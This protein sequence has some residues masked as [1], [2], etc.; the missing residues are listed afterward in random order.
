MMRRLI[1][2]ALFLVSWILRPA[3]AALLIQ[4]GFDLYGYNG[5]WATTNCVLDSRMFAAGAAYLATS[6]GARGGPCL[7]ISGNANGVQSGYYWGVRLP[8]DKVD[9][10]FGVRV[11]P[12]YCAAASTEMIRVRSAA[13]AT[14]FCLDV[15]NVGRIRVKAAYGGAV[16]A[17]SADG[18][19]TFDVFQFL[20]VQFTCDGTD[21]VQVWVDGVEKIALTS[22]L[23]LRQS[24]AGGFGQLMLGGQASTTSFNTY[25][26]DLYIL[27]SSGDAPFND[28]LGDQKLDGHLPTA[29]GTGHD[30]THTAASV[31]QSINVVGSAYATNYTQSDTVGQRAGVAITPNSFTTIHA[32]TIRAYCRNPGGG[33]AK[34]RPYVKIGGTRYYGDEVTLPAD[35]CDLREYVWYKNPALSPPNDAWTTAALGSAELGWE[36]TELTAP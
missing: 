9:G 34:F 31:Y 14:Q 13:A 20:E 36:T 24:G 29:D 3:P 4:E 33:T 21:T 30:W 22:S 8:A 6:F 19:I 16:L 7:Y 11:K 35:T 1:L 32:V 25:Y 27:D 10:V 26:D 28:R 15:T 18:A 23:N 17:E 12:Q 2:S 5:P